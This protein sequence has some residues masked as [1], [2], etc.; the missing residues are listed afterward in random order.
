MSEILVPDETKS[1][2]L[3]KKPSKKRKIKFPP[4]LL[5]K[6]F[7]VIV[8]IVLVIVAILAIKPEVFDRFK[9]SDEISDEQVRDLVF[10]VGK[11]IQLPEGET[12]AIATVSDLEQLKEQDYFRNAQVGDKVL[13]YE[14]I[15]RAYLYRPGVNKIIEV[16][17]VTLESS[18]GGLEEEEKFEIITPT[19]L[20][21]E[22]SPIS[23]P[24]ATLSPTSPPTQ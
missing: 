21:T 20:E 10:E 13:I 18:E 19:P 24:S 14:S 11:I 4:R 16:G 9:K 15:K 6:K 2:A 23:T 12:P 22:P 3:E 5:S 8:L 17:K 1:E 7:L